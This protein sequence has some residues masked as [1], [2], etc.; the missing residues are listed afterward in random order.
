MPA[1]RFRLQVQI[2]SLFGIYGV[3]FT[4]CLFANALA[5]GARGLRGPA[6]A[7]L[8]V[9]VVVFAFGFFRLA[10]PQGT[11]APVAALSDWDARRLSMRSISLAASQRL[12]GEYR[13]R[14]A[15]GSGS[16]RQA[17]RHSGNRAAFIPSG[18]RS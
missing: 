6:L 18:A 17:D 9:C 5:L 12:A 10:T 3:S 1:C 11:V 14:R 13:A 16:G 8:G 7:G 2:A 15:G 4:M